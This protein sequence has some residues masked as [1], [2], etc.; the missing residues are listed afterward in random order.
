MSEESSAQ[1]PRI[2]LRNPVATELST[3]RALQRILLTHPVA[4][5][6]AF[7]ALVAEGRR[8]AAT[9]EGE[10]WRARLVNSSLLQQA[11]LVFDLS[12]VGLLEERTDGALPTSYLDVLFMIASGGDADSLLNQLFW[13]GG[14]RPADA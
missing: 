6:A 13:A 4:A 5:Q 7:T 10:V 8:F 9:P 2:E 12:T 11:R 1:P 3:L 14:E